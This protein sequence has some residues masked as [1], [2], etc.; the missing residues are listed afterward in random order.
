[1][2]KYKVFDVFEN[3]CGG[4]YKKK[5]ICP[6]RSL[7]TQR[8]LHPNT[9]NGFSSSLRQ[10]C[11]ERQRRIIFVSIHYNNNKYNNK[12]TDIEITRCIRLNLGIFL[13]VFSFGRRRSEGSRASLDF[14]VAVEERRGVGSDGDGFV[15]FAE[16]GENAVE[17][18]SAFSEDDA[19]VLR[20]SREE[21]VEGSRL[22]EEDEIGAV[23]FT[24]QA[25]FR[26][27]ELGEH[28]FGG[29]CSDEL[30]PIPFVR[31]RIQLCYLERRF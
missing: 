18:R 20:G 19:L 14:D 11:A 9:R 21:F 5:R 1:M 29:V 12:K 8:S 28:S 13:S 4:K 22:R 3:L 26:R 23:P 31:Y 10:L 16:I 27:R 25:N 7:S 6:E 2:Y 17:G 30:R 15:E 24:Y